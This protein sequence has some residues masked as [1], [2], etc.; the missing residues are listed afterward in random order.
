MDGVTEDDYDVW[1]SNFG[2]PINALSV[3]ASAAVP[4]PGA[5]VLAG[6]VLIGCAAAG[7]F[8]G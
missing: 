7:R 6:L 5:V 8:R 3:S 1:T 2:P 4:E